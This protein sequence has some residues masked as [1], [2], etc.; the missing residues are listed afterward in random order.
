[1][2]GKALTHNE[3]DWDYVRDCAMSFARNVITGP[4]AGMFVLGSYIESAA[5][6]L[7]GANDKRSFAPTV[8]M[9]SRLYSVMNKTKKAFGALK[10][11]CFDDLDAEGLLDATLKTFE[12]VLP[13]LKHGENA[14]RN[15]R[16]MLD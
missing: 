15:V 14:I 10:D 13:P 4:F 11:S 5:G 7:I 12:A 8:P 9:M 3:D 16:E 1:M 6:M 2:L